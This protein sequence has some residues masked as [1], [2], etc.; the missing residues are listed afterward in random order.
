MADLAYLIPDGEP[1][2]IKRLLPHIINPHN[3]TDA[4]LAEHGIARCTVVYPTVEW[5]QTRGERT[6][7]TEQTPHVISWAVETLPLEDVK[8]RA[9]E[10]MK[11]ERDER[12]AGLMPYT[13]PDGTLNHN[14]MT[15]KVI[16]D[17]SASTA[18]AIALSGMGVTHPVMPWTTHENVTHMLTPHQMI[19]FGLAATQW[20]SALHMHSQAVRA[21]IEAAGDV[22]AVVAVGW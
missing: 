5:W 14:Q 19:V 21:Q 8:A 16:R 15:D 3:L 20:H 22:G 11:A 10:R 4:E 2:T 9:W 7:D 17:L 1:T 12:Q 6:I 13:Y 18:A